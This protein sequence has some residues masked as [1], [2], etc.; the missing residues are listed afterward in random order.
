M[1]TSLV[2]QFF[3]LKSAILNI[4]YYIMCK[5]PTPSPQHEEPKLTKGEIQW[6]TFTAAL[7]IEDTDDDKKFSKLNPGYTIHSTLRIKLH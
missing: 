2:F 3:C 5:D 1:N 4:T 7:T 6:K